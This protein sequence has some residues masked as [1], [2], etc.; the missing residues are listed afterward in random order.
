[1]IDFLLYVIFMDLLKPTSLTY[2]LNVGGGHCQFY[3]L[4]ENCFWCRTCSGK[5]KGKVPKRIH[6][7]EREKLKREHLNGLFLD[8]ANSLGNSD[9]PDCLR[10]PPYTHFKTYNIY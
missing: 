6:K 9:S 4:S 8:L 2:Q 10:L 5:N 3:F 7:A 1:M